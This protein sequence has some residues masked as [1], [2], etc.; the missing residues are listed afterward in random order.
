MFVSVWFL[1]DVLMSEHECFGSDGD[2]CF[3]VVAAMRKT[4]VFALGK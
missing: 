1:R 4:F 3:G 2:L